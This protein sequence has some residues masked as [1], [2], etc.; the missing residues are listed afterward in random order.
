MKQVLIIL[1]TFLNCHSKNNQLDY[2]KTI[3]GVENR[4]GELVTPS[5][6]FNDKDFLNLFENS[7]FYLKDAIKFAADTVYSE[8][9]KLISI[10]SMQDLNV[11]NYV[12]YVENCFKV[13]SNKG[14]SE[15]SFAIILHSDM[16]RNNL[17]KVYKHPRYI[18][19]LKEISTSGEVSAKLKNYANSLL[20]EK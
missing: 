10:F 7:D 5:T 15:H 20:R 14:I 3:L 12:E 13:F 17:K 9:Q 4:T 18:K 19:I 1:V 11:N 8:Q 6:L 16:N 2:S